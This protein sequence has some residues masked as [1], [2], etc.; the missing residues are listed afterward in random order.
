MHPRIKDGELENP[1]PFA[2]AMGPM[3][4]LMLHLLFGVAVAALYEALP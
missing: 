4:F 3:G 1:G 2:L